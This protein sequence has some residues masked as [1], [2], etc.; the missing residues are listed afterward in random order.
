VAQRHKELYVACL[1]KDYVMR[2]TRG[3]VNFKY[4]PV[5]MGY[6]PVIKAERDGVQIGLT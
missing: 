1:N 5:C 3:K 4:L 6:L 2:N